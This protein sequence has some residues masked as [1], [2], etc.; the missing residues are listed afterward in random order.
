MV[1]WLTELLA[2]IPGTIIIWELFHIEYGTNPKT[3][4]L[5]VV[6][7]H[8]LIGEL[9]KWLSSLIKDVVNPIDRKFEYFEL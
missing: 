3:L 6:Y 1:I 9:S 7:A 5:E 4:I 8:C 2:K